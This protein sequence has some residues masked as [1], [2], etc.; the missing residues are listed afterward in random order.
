MVDKIIEHM[1]NTI[2]DEWILK[3]HSLSGSFEDSLEGV[4]E[5]TED[6]TIIS[7]YG[8]EYGHYMNKGVE[9]QTIPYTRRN[10]GQGQGGTSKYLTG[11]INYVKMR[12]GISDIKKA[13]GIAFAIAEKHKRD[14][15]LGS[16]FLDDAIEKMEVDLDV[17]IGDYI[18]DKALK[19]LE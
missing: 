10:R 7:I 11:L 8:N 4:V 18:E 2:K 5:E 1:I 17:M 16:G 6:K 13:T 19:K 15:I 12:M 3:G 9:A 14:G